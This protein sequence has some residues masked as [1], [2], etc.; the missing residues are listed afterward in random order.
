MVLI[1]ALAPGEELISYVQKLSS[2]NLGKIVVINDGSGSKYDPVFQALELIDHCIVLT[3]PQNRGKGAA[4][5]TG[6][7]YFLNL[8]NLN[9]YNGVISADSDGQHR[10]EDVLSLCGLLQD[11]REILLGVRDFTKDYIPSKR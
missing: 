2:Y 1:P 9:D 8:K 4:L 5:K 7:Q 6:F 10:I 11:K 3:H